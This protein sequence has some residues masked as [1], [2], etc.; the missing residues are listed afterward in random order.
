FGDTRR[1]DDNGALAYEVNG[2]R[3]RYVVAD[4]GTFA[5]EDAFGE[6]H[7][8]GVRVTG[9]T[10]ASRRAAVLLVLTALV[11]ERVGWPPR[12]YRGTISLD[13]L[14]APGGYFELASELRLDRRFSLALHAGGG[15][16][17]H[18]IGIGK[19]APLTLAWEIGLEPRWFPGLLRN[20]V[21]LGWSMR[22]ARAQETVGFESLQVPPG[23]STGLLVGFKSDFFGITPDFSV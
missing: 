17:Q 16:R 2:E 21:Y 15:G 20:S 8:T 1:F 4:D 7:P 11:I 9:V 22:F 13:V 18:P 14:S 10:P 23:L 12:P 5:I 6:A 19:R 3:R